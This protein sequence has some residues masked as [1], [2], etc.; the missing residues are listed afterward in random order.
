M[1]LFI[2]FKLPVSFLRLQ[3]IL[4]DTKNLTHVFKGHYSAE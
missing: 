2:A 4:I 3:M 1:A